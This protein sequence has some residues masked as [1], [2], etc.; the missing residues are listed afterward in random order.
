LKFEVGNPSNG[1]ARQHVGVGAATRGDA[2]RV[3][4]LLTRVGV[5]RR[6]L[7]APRGQPLASV[8]EALLKARPHAKK[9]TSDSCRA[10]A[11]ASAR[12]NRSSE[13]ATVGRARHFLRNPR[14]PDTEYFAG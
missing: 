12:A 13:G 4:R 10:E 2:P 14:I 5:G 6:R 11:A 8:A 9:K 1:Q 7:A 3:A